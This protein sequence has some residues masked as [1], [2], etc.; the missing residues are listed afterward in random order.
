M[1]R[2]DLHSPE[3]YSEL[4]RDLDGLQEVNSYKGEYDI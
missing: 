4:L 3:S 1:P 2:D